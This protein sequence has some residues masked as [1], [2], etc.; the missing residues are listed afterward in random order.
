MFQECL[1]L[2]KK[3][4]LKESTATNLEDYKK[5]NKKLWLI[6]LDYSQ[7]LKNPV[8]TLLRRLLEVV[9]RKGTPTKYGIHVSK[10]E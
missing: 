5:E 6:G 9:R 2:D 8:K 1:V 4:Q 7:S 10:P 3:N